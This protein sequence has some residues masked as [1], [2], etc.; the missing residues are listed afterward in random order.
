DDHG[1][2]NVATVINR[3]EAA[4]FHFTRARVDIDDADIAAE[5]ESQVGRII[6]RHRL[7]AGLHPRWMIGVRRKSDLLDGLRALGG[8]FDEEFP[9]LPLQVLLARFEQMRC[10]FPGLVANLPGGN[11][12]RRPRSRSTAAG[13]RAET[14]WSRVGV[15]FFDLNISHWDPQLLGEDLSV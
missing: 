7:E 3:H 2:D 10:D 4:N 6:V 8:A 11:G 9:G 1:V 12:R 13:V 15:A 14:I 5:R